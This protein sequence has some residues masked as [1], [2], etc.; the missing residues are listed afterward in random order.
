MATAT[1]RKEFLGRPVTAD[2]RP[3]YLGLAGQWYDHRGWFSLYDVERMRRDPQVNFG[4]RI[5]RAPLHTVTWKVES[6]RGAVSQWVD[7]TLKF[8]WERELVKLTRILEYGYMGGENC[9]HHDPE[10]DT[11]EYTGLRDL[12][13]FDIRPLAVHGA[14]A[15]LSVKGL[16][17]KDSR[18]VW[19]RPPRSFWLANESEYGNLYG[20]PRIAPAWYPWMEKMARHGAVDIRRLWFLKNA[21]R[22]GIIR[23]PI[24]TIEV[25]NGQY[26]SNQDYARELVE[27]METGGVLALP[28]VSDERGNQLWVFEEPKINGD[29]RGVREYPQDLDKEILVGMGIQPEVAQA[30][31]VGGGWSGRSVPFLVFLT[32]EDQV[33]DCM[34]H[35]INEQILRPGVDV[36][37]GE[38]AKYKV[39]LKSLVPPAEEKQ[40]KQQRKGPGDRPGGG[41][42]PAQ[43]DNGNGGNGNGQLPQ[44]LSHGEGSRWTRYEGPRGG[45]GWRNTATNQIVYGG[46]QPGSDTGETA[47][48][49]KPEGDPGGQLTRKQLARSAKVLGNEQ[50]TA[51]DNVREAVSEQLAEVLSEA[52]SDESRLQGDIAG[53]YLKS[54]LY[55]QVRSL[56]EQAFRRIKDHG[57]QLAEMLRTYHPDMEA[58]AKAIEEEA[59]K[60]AREAYRDYTPALRHIDSEF[61]ARDFYSP[62]LGEEKEGVHDTLGDAQK[63][64]EDVLAGPSGKVAERLQALTTQAA[65]VAAQASELAHAGEEEGEHSRY[66]RNAPLPENTSTAEK[67]KRAEVLALP[68]L[69]GDR[70]EV[71]IGENARWQALGTLKNFLADNESRLSSEARGWTRDVLKALA[72]NTEADFWVSRGVESPRWF[73][74]NTVY[75]PPK[76]KEEFSRL[77][78]AHEEPPQRLS[79]LSFDESK[80]PRG[81]PENAGEFAKKPGGKGKTE[82]PSSED[83]P[84]PKTPYDQW[85]ERS[86]A[87]TDARAAAE[88]AR[89]DNWDTSQFVAAAADVDAALKDA[90]LDIALEAAKGLVALYPEQWR[91]QEAE[92]R[93]A[94]AADKQ[95]AKVERARSKNEARIAKLSNKI[96]GAFAKTREV[97]EALEKV[98]EEE[99]ELPVEDYTQRDDYPEEPEEPEEDRFP[100]AQSYD[101]AYD[102]YEKAHAQWAKEDARL[103]DL[104]VK[105]MAAY[106]KA[107]ERWEKSVE[108]AQSKADAAVDVLAETLGDIQAD[109]DEWDEEVNAAIYEVSDDIIARLDGEDEEDEG[110]EEDEDEPEQ[111][112]FDESKHPRGQPENAGQFGPGG[113]K[114]NKTTDKAKATDKT[115]GFTG[116]KKDKAGRRIC[117]DEGRRVPCPKPPRPEKPVKP[118]VDELHAEVAKLKQQGVSHDTLHAFAMRL[119]LLNLKEIGELKNKLGVRAAGPK[120]ELARKIAALALTPAPT[121]EEAAAKIKA[122]KDAGAVSLEQAKEVADLLAKLRVKDLGSLKKQLGVRAAGSKAELAKKIAERALAQ[123]KPIPLVPPSPDFTG[124]DARGYRWRDGVQV[125]QGQKPPRPASPATPAKRPI[126]ADSVLTTFGEMLRSKHARTG[127]VPIHE[128]RK[129]LAAQHGA[130]RAGHESLDAVLMRLDHEDKIRLVAIGDRS[131]ATP[132]Q[133]ADSIP[134]ENETFFYVETVQ[135]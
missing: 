102:E 83:K 125:P 68:P 26:M 39:H 94:G 130:E 110:P 115:A 8:I 103:Y 109:L 37:F 78:W 72:R 64:L 15:G 1:D 95:A 97:Q 134:G 74:L 98:Q 18:G 122:I 45:R 12:N 91:A 67:Q 108:K 4:M 114:K 62:T 42:Q 87:R 106:D 31:E 128:L 51:W 13:P 28:N 22:G 14:L 2:Y 105:E 66:D 55:L 9:W 49:E 84:S 16:A 11:I 90:D 19:L 3:T 107:L 119:A 80:H 93:K 89:A 113:G 127:L 71:L 6:D 92:L 20:R 132:E 29:P 33:A 58:E 121:A 88:Q 131:R 81:Q 99:P 53:T 124:I 75:L 43:P 54:D 56:R 82:G 38:G 34:F 21:Y 118:T 47:H 133:L 50:V 44:R 7:R 27:K 123:P 112:S 77:R 60:L 129:T 32:S 85:Q 76:V 36:N 65:E 117:Y 120:A 10:T 86:D 101:K 23:H 17:G 104:T 111:L 126:T 59:G 63:E 61:T 116:E 24:G 70:E 25:A 41:G 35:G 40:A 46:E 48:E 69:K 52:A 73:L 96:E 135:H 79:H 30:A 100:D 57:Q 5:L